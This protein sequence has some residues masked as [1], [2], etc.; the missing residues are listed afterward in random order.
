MIALVDIGNTRFKWALAAD[1]GTGPVGSAVHVTD[2]EAA[3]AALV[4]ALPRNLRRVLAANVA[5]DAVGARL[6]GALRARHAIEIEFVMPAAERY[7]IRCAYDEPARLGV[8]RWVAMIAAHRATPELVCVI[9]AGTAVTFDAVDASG[10][11]LGGLIFPGPRLMADALD[12]KTGG[13]GPTPTTARPATGLK[14]LG[15]STQEAVG[16]GSMLA[17]AAALDRAVAVVA[18]AANETPTA[19]LTGGDAAE[20]APWLESKVRFSADLVLAGLAYIA[21]HGE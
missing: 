21:R 11:H 6:A 18:A 14:L 12:R 20:L 5:G 19:I 8:D 2:L 17:I 7:G 13:I 3:I 16:K 15:T 10:R 1:D 9:Q 4:D